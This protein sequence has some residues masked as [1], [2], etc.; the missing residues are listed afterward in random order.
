VISTVAGPAGAMTCTRGRLTN[1]SRDSASMAT[2]AG[3][4]DLG[5]RHPLLVGQLGKLGTVDQEPLRR[6]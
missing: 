2:G 4:V 3:L 5:K 6:G 1:V